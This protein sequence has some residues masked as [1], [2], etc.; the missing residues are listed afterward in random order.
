MLTFPRET[1]EWLTRPVGSHAPQIQAGQREHC[2]PFPTVF[3]LTLHPILPDPPVT[4]AGHDGHSSP[5]F[6]QAEGP[7]FPLPERMDSWPW[8]SLRR[9]SHGLPDLPCIDPE[10]YSLPP[11]SYC[12]ICRAVCP[13][14]WASP[15]V[16]GAILP[17]GA[18]SAP[19][20]NG[21]LPGAPFPLLGRA[22][23]S[24]TCLSW[25]AHQSFTPGN[26]LALGYILVHHREGFSLVI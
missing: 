24:L 6:L 18:S 15:F 17:R 10:V 8:M 12:S 14:G 20:V 26:S 25:P 2:L 16:P 23:P 9:P 3:V 7:T 4:R 22:L 13:T 21:C 11:R 1:F 19:L 5:Q